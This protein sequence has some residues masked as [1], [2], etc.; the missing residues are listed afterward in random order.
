MGQRLIQTSHPSNFNSA[1]FDPG[2]L[3]SYEFGDVDDPEWASMTPQPTSPYNAK[4]V[5]IFLPQEVSLSP[6]SLSRLEKLIRLMKPLTV[7]VRIR[8]TRGPTHF[9]IFDPVVEDTV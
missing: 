9:R 4:S 1:M 6:R 3:G 2:L 5:E 7:N 8:K